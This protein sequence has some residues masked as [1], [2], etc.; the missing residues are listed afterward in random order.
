M[1]NP[2]GSYFYIGTGTDGATINKDD[3]TPEDVQTWS[4]L[5]TDLAQYESSIDWA[6]ANLVAERGEFQG[7]SF[8]VKDRSGVWFEGTAH[9]AAALE[10][11]NLKGDAQAAAQLIS[12][13]EIGQLGAPNADG[14]GIDAASKDGLATGDGG[15]KYYAS[16][17]IGATA[18]YCLAKLSANPFQML[19]PDHH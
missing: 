1:W 9:A 18:W 16:L 11:R 3:P 6:L 15:D 5:A 8:Q 7:L 10:A 14:R 17:H 19:R 2:K 13:V 4:F 12:D